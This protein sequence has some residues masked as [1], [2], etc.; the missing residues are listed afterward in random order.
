LEGLADALNLVVEKP[1]K[2]LADSESRLDSEVANEWWQYHLSREYSAITALF[3]G[4]FKST[5]TC[6]VCEHK[7]SRFEPFIYLSLPLPAP[8]D[9]TFTF[10][11]VRSAQVMSPLKCAVRVPRSATV[12]ETLQHISEVILG[13]RVALH[14]L[15][16]GEVFSGYIFALKGNERPLLSIRRRDPWYV[17]E[18]APPIGKEFALPPPPLVADLEENAEEGSGSSVKLG[19]VVRVA[20]KINE[21]GK[22]EGLSGPAVVERI[23]PLDGAGGSMDN[24]YKVRYLRT[25]SK[26]D[27]SVWKRNLCRQ[28]LGVL[29]P[30]SSHI[31]LVMRSWQPTDRFYSTRLHPRLTGVPFLVR[32]IPEH[33]SG[34]DLYD[35]VARELRI[36]RKDGDS[37]EL[38]FEL[39]RVRREG[40]ACSTCPWLTS[41][42]GCILPDSEMPITMSFVGHLS[43][44]AV[45]WGVVGTHEAF[46][47]ALRGSIIPEDHPSLRKVE[48][49][50]N[51]AIELN[52]CLQ[53]F[54]LS[55]KMSDVYCGRC[56]DLTEQRKNILLWRAPPILVVHLKRFQQTR[57]IRSKIGSLVNF[58]IELQLGHLLVPTSHQCSNEEND[59]KIGMQSYGGTSH[60]GYPPEYTLYG[61]VNHMGGLGAG[62]YYS[63]VRKGR[64]WYCLD[65][66]AVREIKEGDVVTPAAYILFYCRND[67]DDVLIEDVYPCTRLAPDEVEKIIA[68]QRPQSTASMLLSEKCVLS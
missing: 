12:A 46:P 38:P 20:S 31:T 59:E 25:G 58:P 8:F 61:V 14:H 32:V 35:I 47:K 11:L 65:D 42:F 29:P 22:R 17:F 19:T 21:D 16:L 23:E 55:E 9:F 51:P 15:V 56:K 2:E 41:C 52:E 30:T 24:T 13:G 7:S 18:V 6:S 62:H 27:T 34:R 63:Y 40:I 26:L 33:T 3:N 4:Q 53:N 44:I 64:K 10:T 28:H 45:D 68:E 37:G 66:R 5:I 67:V 39:A 60:G 54:T 48:L 43:T 49:S 57:D 36:T 1:Y 50:A